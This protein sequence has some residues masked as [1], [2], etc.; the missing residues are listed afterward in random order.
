[1]QYPIGRTVVLLLLLGGSA[2]LV[3]SPTEFPE[4]RDVAQL[5]P[6]TE[7]KPLTA[8]IAPR[9]TAV[10]QPKVASA[11]RPAPPPPAG[12]TPVVKV[13]SKPPRPATRTVRMLVTAYCPCKKCCGMFSDNMTASGAV[14]LSY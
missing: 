4:F 13:A 1:M 10:R 7:D 6:E 3:L 2:A 8:L 11:P 9:P 5:L 14:Q 12:V